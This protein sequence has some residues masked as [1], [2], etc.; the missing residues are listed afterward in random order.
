MADGFLGPVFFVWLGAS[1]DLRELVDRPRMIAVAGALALAAVVVHA[2]ARLLGQPLPLALLAGAQLGVP[3]AAVT[4][5]E[6][7]HLLSPGEGGAILAAALVS[8]GITAW[9]AAIARRTAHPE[10]SAA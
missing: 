3:V 7:E 4:I 1:V 9:M 10:A 2:A 6:R 5:G 8:V